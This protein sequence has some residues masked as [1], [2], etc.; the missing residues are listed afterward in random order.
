LP[1]RT[2]SSAVVRGAADRE[3]VHAVDLDA[4]DAEALAAAVELV[5]G[6]ARL[7]LVPIAYWLFSIT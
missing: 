6:A 2:H 5:L 7:T 4:G 3:H 1:A